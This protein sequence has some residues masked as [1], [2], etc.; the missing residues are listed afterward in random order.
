MAQTCIP[1]Y[2]P[3]CM[4]WSKYVSNFSCITQDMIWQEF[5][6]ANNPWPKHPKGLFLLHLLHKSL[7]F[8]PLF[9][10]QYVNILHA[11]H[12][13]LGNLSDL[14]STYIEH[15][16]W[17]LSL[18]SRRDLIVFFVFDSSWIGS[19]TRCYSREWINGFHPFQESAWRVLARLTI[20]FCVQG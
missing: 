12:V 14:S 7:Q 18:K 15:T 13:S 16:Q 9:H 4:H 6:R 20:P 17:T 19:I 1:I 2:Q 5:C 10:S 3:L 8:D 11:C